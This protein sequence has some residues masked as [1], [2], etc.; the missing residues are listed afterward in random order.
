M[1]ISPHIQDIQDTYGISRV[2][3]S[4]HRIYGLDRVKEGIVQRVRRPHMEGAHLEL[5]EWTDRSPHG[6][7]GLH[8]VLQRKDRPSCATTSCGRRFAQPVL[9]IREGCAVSIDVARLHFCIYAILAN[10]NFCEFQ[11]LMTLLYML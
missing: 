4:P 2:H 9:P 10:L 6:L 3:G 11:I 7:Y 5:T 8:G 1:T